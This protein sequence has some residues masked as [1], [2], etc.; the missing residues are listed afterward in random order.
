MMHFSC[1]L[2][3]K[4]IQPGD[5]QRYIVKIETC[6][7]QNSTQMTEADLEDD[8]MQE[9]SQLLRSMEDNLDEQDGPTNTDFRFD[10]CPN[11]HKR[12][13]RDPLGKEQSHKLFFSKN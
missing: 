11:C 9:I 2:C 1:D 7:A 12:F 5:D 10:L 3:G 13:V 8:H 4:T 6:A